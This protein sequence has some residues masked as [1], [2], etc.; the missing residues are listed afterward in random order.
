MKME[1]R[2][3]GHLTLKEGRGGGGGAFVK[4]AARMFSV[5]TPHTAPHTTS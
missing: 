3:L 1:T 5:V 4:Q 2:K